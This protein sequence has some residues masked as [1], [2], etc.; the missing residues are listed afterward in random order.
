MPTTCPSPGPANEVANPTP[1]YTRACFQLK[2]PCLTPSLHPKPTQYMKPLQLFELQG[3]FILSSN[4][5]FHRAEKQTGQIPGLFM[6]TGSYYQKA[7]Y[8]NFLSLLPP[9]LKG[10]NCSFKYLDQ[11]LLQILHQ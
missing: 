6:I 9:Y 1:V 10:R 8:T 3:H 2:S 7:A 4:S 5:S 11:L